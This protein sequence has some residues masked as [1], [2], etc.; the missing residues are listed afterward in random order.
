M[1]MVLLIPT[2]ESFPLS[3]LAYDLEISLRVSAND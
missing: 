2:L 1:S 3:I